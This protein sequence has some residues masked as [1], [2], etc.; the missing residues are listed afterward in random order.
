M[1]YKGIK[2]GEKARF[3]IDQWNMHIFPFPLSR[4][5]KLGTNFALHCTS[6][7][8]NKN[9]LNLISQLCW[10]SIREDIEGEK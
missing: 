3:L 10:C 2:L 1:Y 7:I 5:P 8:G 4:R 6:R 9:D